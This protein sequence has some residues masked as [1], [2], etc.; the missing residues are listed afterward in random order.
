M[1]AFGTPDMQHAGNDNLPPII[2][3]CDLKRKAQSVHAWAL[4]VSPTR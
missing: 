1:P 4:V 2:V 3:T